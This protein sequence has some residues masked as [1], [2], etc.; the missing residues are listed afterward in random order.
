VTAKTDRAR[1][2]RRDP[3]K[4]EA[5]LWRGLRNRHLTGW[6]FRRQH[7]VAGF[8]A[9]FATIAGRLIVEIDG[10][11]HYVGN[12]PTQDAERTGRLQAMGWRVIRFTN[13][14]VCENLDGVLQAIADVLS[15]RTAPLPPSPGLLRKPTSP[16]VGGRGS[17]AFVPSSPLPPMGGEVGNASAFPGEGGVVS[18]SRHR[19]AR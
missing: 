2:L 16:P 3:P 11:N 9:D 17:G 14:E 4:P 13:V 5:I 7:P 12:G 8:I 18:T 15:N 6:K 19:A 10:E 1:A